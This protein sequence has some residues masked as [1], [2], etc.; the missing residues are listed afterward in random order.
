MF[1]MFA[2]K[3]DDGYGGFM[4]DIKPLGYATL[5]IVLLLLLVAIACFQTKS[6]KTTVF[7]PKQLVFA[8]I[9][10]AL[11]MVTSNLKLFKMPMGGSVTLCSMLFITVIGYWYGFKI[12]LTT[13]LSY[14]LLQLII[15]PYVISFP[16]LFVDY[17]F[18]FGAL[19]L[20][21]VFHNS[22]HGLIKGYLLGVFGRFVFSSL[23]GIIF[24]YSYAIEKGMSPFWY[25]VSYN[26][27]YLGMEAILT[28]LIIVIPTVS[29]AFSEVKHMAME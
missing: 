29:K 17:I 21:G 9:A 12:G 16:Q 5:I 1:E 6:K 25:S 15:D 27:S 24:F 19:G 14:G 2:S 11:A 28:L 10:I 26:G 23:S 4:Y 18:A 7:R 22:K 8:S 13:A 3:V 20:S